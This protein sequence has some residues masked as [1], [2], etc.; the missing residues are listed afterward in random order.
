M[1]FARCDGAGL[2]PLR[3]PSNEPGALPQA[4]IGRA[5]G[6]PEGTATRNGPNQRAEGFATCNPQR[7]CVLSPTYGRPNGAT[8]RPIV[9]W[10][11]APGLSAQPARAEGPA[12]AVGALRWSGPSALAS[13]FQRTWGVAP[14][15]YRSRRWRF[16]AP[17]LRLKRGAKA[18]LALRS[19]VAAVEARRGR[20]VG[21]S[22]RGSK[23]LGRWLTPGNRAPPTNTARVRSS[24]PPARRRGPAPPGSPRLAAS[25]GD[26]CR[27]PPPV[28]RAAP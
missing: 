5:V 13:T 24:P 3:P 15:Y 22:E 6:A 26:E 18:P 21:A 8:P 12:H 19:A 10:G 28:P 7:P 2:Q 14:G 25:K 4:T 1:P 16:G 17:L 23:R 11:N 9:A 27:P 20:A